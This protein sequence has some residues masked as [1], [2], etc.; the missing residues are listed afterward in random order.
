MSPAIAADADRMEAEAST[1]YASLYGQPPA[2]TVNEESW[3]DAARDR[4][5]D[6]REAARCIRTQIKSSRE[7]IRTYYGLAVDV[8]LRVTYG[9][10]GATVVGFAGQ[11][12]A[13]LRDGAAEPVVVHATASVEYPPG[14]SVGPGPDERYAHLVETRP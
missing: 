6:L 14:V 2:G 4:I 10:E 7:H 9:G 5:E 12:L 3:R 8:G 11:Y 13:V 1:L